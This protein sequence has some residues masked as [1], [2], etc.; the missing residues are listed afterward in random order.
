MNRTN[1]ST[2]STTYVKVCYILDDQAEVIT[3]FPTEKSILVHVFALIFVIF[4][5]PTTVSLNGIT[6]FTIQRSRVLK[7]RQS[8]FTILMQSMVDL[9]NGALIMPLILVH[10]SSEAAGSPRCII[11]YVLKKSGILMFLY[12][13]TTLSVMNFER[14]MGI[15]HP[16]RHRSQVTNKRLLAYVVAVCV[17]Q[18]VIFAFSLTHNQI[19][20][21]VLLTT[22]FLFLF[23]TIFVY[24]KIFLKMHARNRVGII[25]C[26]TNSQQS[27]KSNIAS[28]EKRNK[29]AQFLKELKIAKSSCLVVVC[30]LACYLPCT[31]AFGPLNV[32]GTFEAVALKIYFV[33]LAGLNSTLNSIIYFWMNN[34]L[35]KHGIDM[36]KRIWKFSKT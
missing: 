26:D 30:C 17:M 23:T 3:G 4:L 1:T 29:H 2:N 14:Y 19:S 5:I 24:W 20:R 35:R 32:Q 16:F 34:M 6:V 12:S 8:N 10:L 11:I 21:S 22:T 33:V 36:V 31:L 9:A 15:L 28:A 25:S 18:T 7:E 13:L 27:N